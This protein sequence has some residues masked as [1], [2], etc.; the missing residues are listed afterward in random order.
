MTN[1]KE[2]QVRLLLADY[3]NY[4]PSGPQEA[5]I[6]VGSGGSVDAWPITAELERRMDKTSLVGETYHNLDQ[7]LVLLDIMEPDLYN[8]ILAIYLREDSGHR[9]LDHLTKMAGTSE[10]IHDLVERE[11]RAVKKLVSFL[12]NVDLYVRS[13]HKSSGP[14]PGQNMQEKHD[15]LFAIYQRNVEDGLAHGKAISNAV[16]KMVDEHGSPYYSKRHAI[17]VINSRLESVEA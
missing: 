10:S 1:T 14:R 6:P 5:Y 13:P 7:A 4:L 15:E 17:R 3:M 9:D 12:D 16:F 8:A 11:N 2:R